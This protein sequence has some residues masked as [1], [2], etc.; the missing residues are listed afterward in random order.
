MASKGTRYTE[1]QIKLLPIHE[2]AYGRK[3]YL[4]IQTSPA[5]YRT[6]DALG[7]QLLHFSLLWYCPGEVWIVR[8]GS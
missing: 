7:A 3:G 8:K 1:Q 5:N 2:C 4:P 6:P